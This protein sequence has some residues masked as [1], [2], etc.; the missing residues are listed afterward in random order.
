[1]NKYVN[2]SPSAT[3]SFFAISRSVKSEPHFFALAGKP[4]DTTPFQESPLSYLLHIF[5]WCGGFH[6]EE[7]PLKGGLILV[8]CLFRYC[9]DVPLPGIKIAF[10]LLDPQ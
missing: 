7:C 3:A 1:M 5:S 10:G 9:Q 4:A 8:A 2:L 6:P